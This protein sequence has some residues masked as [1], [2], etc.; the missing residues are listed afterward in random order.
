MQKGILI[1][2]HELL[3]DLYSFNLKAYCD[4]ELIQFSSAEEAIL[5]VQ[6]NI[7][8]YSIIISLSQ[9]DQNDIPVQFLKWLKSKSVDIPLIIIGEMSQLS[10]SKKAY[11]LPPNLNIPLVVKTCAKILNITAKDMAAKE[12][13]EYYPLPVSML[14]N[15]TQAPCHVFIKVGTTGPYEYS[16]TLTE[17]EDLKP[18]T[19]LDS[20]R[21]DGISTLYIPSEMRLKIV[22]EASR[23][24]MDKLDDP[25]LSEQDKLATVEQGYEV[26]GG[27]LGENPEITPQIVDISK[28]CMES[29]TEVLDKVP[30]LKNLIGMMLQNK[31][32]H[33]YL[34]SVM[35][36]YISR[37]IVKNISWGSDE[38]A[39]KLS[40]VFYFHDIFLAPIFAK[41]PDLKS[42]ENLVFQEGISEKEKEIVVNH[43][44]MASEMVKNFPRCP[45]GADAIIS[46][47]HGTSNGMGF[48]LEYK[49]DISPLAKVLIVSEAFVD[50]LII[51]KDKGIKISPDEI[52]EKLRTKFTKHTYKK[53][54]NSLENIPF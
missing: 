34:H 31:T 46:Q 40:F 37:H 4:L 11:T 32:G 29:V 27:L 13:P 53:I 2:N 30:K 1:S 20:Y 36:T 51:A 52:I 23:L 39:E 10:N 33:L 5:G 26:I 44:R 14:R 49:D 42:E 19:K 43:A 24:V 54:I 8:D 50:E 3:N 28:K 12:V 45:M 15:F 17:G 18:N 7:T 6:T 16:Q 47:H 22:N 25:T 38:H 21:A 48:A 41:Y 35:G 9:I